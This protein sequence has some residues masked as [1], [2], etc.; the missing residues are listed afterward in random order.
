[1]RTTLL[2][3]VL[4][5]ASLGAA[6]GKRGMSPSPSPADPSRMN[7]PAPA[8]FK[9]Q[10]T[11]TKG[12]FVVEV[13]RDWAPHGADRFYNLVRVGFFDGVKFFR[14]IKGFMVQF[15][16]NGDPAVSRAWKDSDIP[17]DPVKQSNTRGHVTFATAGPGTRTTQIFINLVDNKR[18]DGS[19]FSPFARVI[20]GMEVVDALYG[21]YG[22]GP[23]GGRG[24]DQDRIEAEG[25][26]YLEKEFPLLDGVKTARI[27]P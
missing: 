3:W 2:F 13:Q 21:G 25:T 4:L 9:T 6:C 23:P 19:G 5:S 17:D 22:E 7:E 18:L 24:P 8:V 1:M 26:A 10:F 12:D 11:T 14:T 15:G 20:S 27:V 16:I